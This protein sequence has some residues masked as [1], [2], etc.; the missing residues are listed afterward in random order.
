MHCGL[1]LRADVGLRKIEQTCL[2]GPL[3]ELRRRDWAYIEHIFSLTLE[4]HMKIASPATLPIQREP[5]KPSDLRAKSPAQ[6]S[7]PIKPTKTTGSGEQKSV[8]PGLERAL[9]RLQSLPSPNTGQ[10]NATDRISRNIARYAETQAIGTPPAPPPVA[11]TT[12]VESLE[13]APMETSA[14]TPTPEVSTL[15]DAPD[16]AIETTV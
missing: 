2:S 8:P 4:H 13:T 1:L 12:L 11:P 6:A 5:A 14:S 3:V 9:T 7:D 15:G 10:A 16:S